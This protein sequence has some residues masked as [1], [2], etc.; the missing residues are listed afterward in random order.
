MS[1]KETKRTH[2]WGALTLTSMLALPLFWPHR[3]VLEFPEIVSESSH[4]PYFLYSE[5][6]VKCWDILE[7]IPGCFHIHRVIYYSDGSY[8]DVNS[9]Y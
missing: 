9:R 2:G 1:K 8:S 7:D 5:V 6:K 4:I 3:I